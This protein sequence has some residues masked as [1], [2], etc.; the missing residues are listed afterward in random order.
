MKSS[1]THFY[2]QA[3]VDNGLPMLVT[4]SKDEET[5]EEYHKFLDKKQAVKLAKAEKEITPNIKFRVVT[6]VETYE[7]G[8]WL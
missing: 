6:C 4:H 2:V 5:G 1:F 8:E 7:A 3:Q